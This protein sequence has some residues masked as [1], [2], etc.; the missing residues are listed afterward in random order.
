MRILHISD[1]HTLARHTKRLAFLR[2]LAD[3]MPDL[4]IITGDMIAEAKAIG[5]VLDALD[6]LLDVPGVF[7]FGS[8]D[9]VEPTFKTRSPTWL[10]R[11]IALLR[12][13]PLAGPFR[14]VTCAPH[15]WSA[16]G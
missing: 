1:A 10:A 5:P 14:G 9:Y 7:V 11:P 16:V 6:K 13:V 4:V 3:T 12:I 2:D 15:S 8:N